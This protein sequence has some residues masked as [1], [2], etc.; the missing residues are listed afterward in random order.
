MPLTPGHRIDLVGLAGAFREATAGGQAA[1]F[2]LC[3]PHNPTGTVHTRDELSAVAGLAARY[4]VRVVAD[5]I[6]APLAFP[7]AGYVPYLSVPGTDDGFAL[8]IDQ[9]GWQTSLYALFGCSLVTWISIELMSR[10]YDGAQA[11]A[12]SRLAS[13]T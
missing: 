8:L 6:H 12:R 13:E 5:E 7:D 3:S 11:R 1:A 4:G 10:W 2:L 9:F